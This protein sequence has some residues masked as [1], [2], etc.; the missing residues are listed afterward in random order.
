MLARLMMLRLTQL[1]LTFGCKPFECSCECDVRISRVHA[2]YLSL[3]HDQEAEQATQQHSSRR[4]AQSQAAG[5]HS[6][7]SWSDEQSGRS[8]AKCQGSTEE[9]YRPPIVRDHAAIGCWTG[10]IAGKVIGHADYRVT[11]KQ[12]ESSLIS[13]NS[14]C[15]HQNDMCRRRRMREEGRADQKMPTTTNM[16]TTTDPRISEATN[17]DGKGDNMQTEGMWQH[18]QLPDREEDWPPPSQTI[19][20]TDPHTAETAS[21]KN[22]NNNDNEGRAR[23]T[24]NTNDEQIKSEDVIGRPNWQPNIHPYNGGSG[25]GD[26]MDLYDPRGNGRGAS[27]ITADSRANR[28]RSGSE[29]MAADL[30]DQMAAASAPQL[31]P[32]GPT[33]FGS[34][35][36]AGTTE[37]PTMSGAAIAPRSDDSPSRASSASDDRA[38]ISNN[39]IAAMLIH[40]MYQ[41]MSPQRRRGA[42]RRISDV[43]G[44][45]VVQQY[46][47]DYERSMRAAD[48]NTRQRSAPT[49]NPTRHG[50][51]PDR[52]APAQP[53]DERD[54]EPAG[55]IRDQGP[56]GQVPHDAGIR[57][58]G[59]QPP[60]INSA[61]NNHDPS[62]G[63]F[64]NQHPDQIP[65]IGSPGWASLSPNM[66]RARPSQTTPQRNSQPQVPGSGHGQS[67]PVSAIPA[68]P[69]QFM[70]PSADSASK[71]PKLDILDSCGEQAL[72]RWRAQLPFF[73]AQVRRYQTYTNPYYRV[74]LSDW[75]TDDVWWEISQDHL[76]PEDRT[77]GA[78]MN[79][80]AVEDFLRQRGKYTV[81]EEQRGTVH[82]ASPPDEFLK[83][84]WTYRKGGSY[85]KPFEI[86]MRKWRKLMSTMPQR[87]IPNTDDLAQIMYGKIKPVE[88]RRRIDD[89]CRSGRDPN[90]LNRV[91]MPWRRKAKRDWKLMKELI[92]ENAEQM[93]AD[94]DLMSEENGQ[95][96]AQLAIV[97]FP[98]QAT[99]PAT[100][101]AISPSANLASSA[102]QPT[103]RSPTCASPGCFARVRKRRD[104]KGF[105]TYCYNHAHLWNQVPTE[106]AA[107]TAS[108]Q[109][110]QPT[111]AGAVAGTDTK[112]NAES[113]ATQ[114][115]KPWTQCRLAG[116]TQP[117]YTDPVKGWRSP[118]CSLEHLKLWRLTP[119]GQARATAH[120]RCWNCDGDHSVLMCPALTEA[121]R[122]AME[123]HIGYR[124]SIQWWSVEENRNKAKAFRITDHA[125]PV[126]APAPA[127]TPASAP[128][129]EPGLMMRQHGQ[130]NSPY[131]HGVATLMGLEVDAYFD[132]GGI[133]ILLSDDN[134]VGIEQAVRN[135]KLPN[136]ELITPAELGYSD[137]GIPIDVACSTR[138]QGGHQSSI[139]WI[140]R[141]VRTN[142]SIVTKTGMQHLLTRQ[143]VG[144]V[145]RSTPLL[146]IG[147]EGCKLCGYKT[148]EEQDAELKQNTNTC[149][150]SHHDEQIANR[151][152]RASPMH[153]IA[154]ARIPDN[155]MQR[156]PAITVEELTTGNSMVECQ[157]DETLTQQI[158]ADGSAYVGKEAHKNLELAT[159]IK[160]D[161]VQTM[162]ITTAVAVRASQQSVA[163]K[164]TGLG[165]RNK[166][167]GHLWQ[168]A[169]SAPWQIQPSKI[170]YCTTG[171]SDTTGRM[172]HFMQASK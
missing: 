153:R 67:W 73:N 36:A 45:E 81:D 76:L 48:R 154:H 130:P 170:K 28:P 46:L 8:R 68:M 20:A 25:D 116:C 44:P 9:T 56:H 77:T 141:W 2:G 94:A 88:L 47:M 125:N 19:R 117:R 33:D 53:R 158:V 163:R 110:A 16:K 107:T 38:G 102:V 14:H 74:Q 30:A 61:A 106:T 145:R 52:H 41:S 162:I 34:P 78:D 166:E 161:L 91:A 148:I 109:P 99:T 150:V 159:F 101:L 172:P 57:S 103:P 13:S 71:R 119:A 123:K 49:A 7:P 135:G 97:P 51:E 69:Y 31:E 59:F 10:G 133:R 122:A 114:L 146:I 126:A 42:L 134:Y 23:G 127:P 96:A 29:P 149:N 12:Y 100:M 169:N 98:A 18:I 167:V 136:T 58:A 105:F 82:Y 70:M 60:G 65:S 92:R 75:V 40:E 63:A 143:V 120:K 89:R 4:N 85:L 132:L 84:T 35:P 87:D 15:E 86:F 55:A 62:F 124:H 165:L 27:G 129:P 144:F 43:V 79:D 66:P 131:A 171:W 108:L 1:M 151:A 157:H 138:G 112:V 22:D 6:W 142:I 147:Q 5:C 115:A 64:I 90:R 121:K 140:K 80:A 137:K 24:S 156:N 113:S 17:D 54:D 37:M 93:D 111:P 3:L 164:T 83:L 168:N 95:V 152:Q 155:D 21:V 32:S 72:G 139:V 160:T 26:E 11:Q 118:C 50:R 104:G 128:A 39:G